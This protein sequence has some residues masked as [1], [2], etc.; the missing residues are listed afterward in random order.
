VKI[1]VAYDGSPE[2]KLAIERAA[3]IAKLEGAEVAVISVVPIT[4]SGRGGGIDPTDDVPEH[5]RQLDDAIAQ[6]AALG[7]HAREIETVGH[8]ADA[9]IQTA[10]NEGTNL[11]VIGSRGQSGIK[12][13][14]MGSVSTHV[15]QH[16][17][18]NV[19]IA[20]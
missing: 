14:L 12:R 8:P 3:E 18:C 4:A 15:S 19:Y 6:L 7:T 11:I 16:A 13:F 9:I 20:R 10:E 2:S 1:L 17:P 5:A